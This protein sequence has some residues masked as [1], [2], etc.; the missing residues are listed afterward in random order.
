MGDEDSG[1][2]PTYSAG[3]AS[4][5]QLQRSG[6]AF[7]MQD[8]YND[9]STGFQTQ[10]GFIQSSNFRENHTHANYQWYPKHKFYQSYGSNKSGYRFRSSGRPR[11]SLFHL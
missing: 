5:F 10:L 6:H 4:A 7:N 9:V 11:L 3:P 2:P 8:Q 1:T